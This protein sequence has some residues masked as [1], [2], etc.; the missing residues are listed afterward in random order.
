MNSTYDSV[1]QFIVFTYPALVTRFLIDFNNGHFGA[2]CTLR[3]LHRI[4][5]PKELNVNLIIMGAYVMTPLVRNM[6]EGKADILSDKDMA[7]LSL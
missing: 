7:K 6:G 2:L 4:V 5:S 3:K 1:A